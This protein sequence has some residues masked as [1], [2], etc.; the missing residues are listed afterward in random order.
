MRNFIDLLEDDAGYTYLYRGDASNVEKYEID[1]TEDFLALFGYG[2]YL[3][4]SHEVAKDYTVKGSPEV[5]FPPP[6]DDDNYNSANRLLIGFIVN[7]ML[8]NGFKEAKQKMIEKYSF[9]GVRNDFK[10]ASPEWH[11]REEEI[12]QM[13]EADMNAVKHEYIQKAF[14]EYKKLKKTMK[15]AKLTTGEYVF[16]KNKRS[17]IISKFK[18]PNAYIERVLHADRPLSDAGVEVVRDLYKRAYKRFAEDDNAILDLRT[19]KPSKDLNKMNSFDEF[20]RDYKK[21]G[22]RYAWTD[23][24][25]KMGGKG[26][27]PSLDMFMNGTHS[28]HSA[29]KTDRATQKFVIESFQK[30]G[31]VGFEYEGGT[32]LTGTGTRGGGKH[33]HRAF[34]F[35]DEEAINSFREENHPYQDRNIGSIDR[36]FDTSNVS[37]YI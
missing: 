14:A 12:R 27:N 4:N 5:I 35:W 9:G 36:N 37:A 31:Y 32:K 21:Y 17:A 22:S 8:N 15:I 20:V 18:V 1:K 29:F 23:D 19:L 10:Y 30:L 24:N 2:I 25:R 16:V 34:V 26:E 3:T 33:L 11:A 28:G 7:L 6:S 13:R